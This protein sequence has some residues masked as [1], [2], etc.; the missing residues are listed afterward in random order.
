M[1][2]D[3]LEPTPLSSKIL[4]E[5]NSNK[6][7]GVMS[8]ADPID[9]LT[10]K[11]CLPTG[12]PN[13]DRMLCLSKKG[14]WGLP[15]GKIVSIKSKPAVGK[16]TFLL[17]VAKQAYKRGGAVCIIESEHALDLKYAKRLNGPEVG[18]YLVSQPDTLE[19]A[20]GVVENLLDICIHKRKAGDDSPFVIMMDSF[21]GF[22]PKDELEGD[23]KVGGK[24]MGLH[25]RIASQACRKLTGRISKAKALL[26]LSHQLKSKIGVFWGN[27]DT[28]IGGDAF[29]YHDSICLTF[30]KSSAIKDSGKMILGHYAVVKTT[31]NKLYPPHREARVKII[32]GRGFEKSFSILEFLLS[33]RYIVKKGGHFHFKENKDISWQGEEKFEEFLK[34]NSE[35]RN[36]VK[37]LLKEKSKK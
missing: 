25:A 37:T 14:E 16:T 17:R 19:E 22:S 34:E 28:N 10:V 21:S 29:N 1:T 9:P 15:I 13:V 11:D 20:F 31:K 27:P 12:L 24:A 35:A 36:L 26:I 32:N 33:Y 23:F 18:N 5:V 3:I 7:L 8:F 6:G 2:K 30:T 4:T